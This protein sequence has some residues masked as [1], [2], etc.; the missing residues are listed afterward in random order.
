MLLV[1][2]ASN[3]SYRAHETYYMHILL[4]NT[5]IRRTVV[6]RA[7]SGEHCHSIAYV[8]VRAFCSGPMV[9][10]TQR[11]K[12]APVPSFFQ[13]PHPSKHPSIYLSMHRGIHT[14]TGA[15]NS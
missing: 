1:C 5:C 4:N 13:A 7:D 6:R 15:K 14:Q 11:V 8:A 3:P 9:V 2:L 12:Q 10:Y